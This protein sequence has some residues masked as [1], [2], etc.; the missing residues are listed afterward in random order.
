MIP[1]TPQYS[2]VCR[3]FVGKIFW[4]LTCLLWVQQG[5]RFTCPGPLLV[6]YYDDTESI[7]I[8]GLSNA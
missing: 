5:A 4:T 3:L 2:A 6:H 1:E 7:I 8:T